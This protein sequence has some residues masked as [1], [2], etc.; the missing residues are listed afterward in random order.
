R[1]R[2]RIQMAGDRPAAYVPRGF[3]LDTSTDV[4]G[5]RATRMEAT[6]GRHI[7][8][9]RQRADQLDTLARAYTHGRRC[10]HQGTSV[11]ML[12]RVQHVLRTPDLHQLAQVHDAHMGADM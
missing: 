12:W 8:R 2:F 5:M 1:T 6:S 11:R 7:C 3:W 9:I 10:C 4:H